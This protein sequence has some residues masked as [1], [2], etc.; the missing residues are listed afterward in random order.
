MKLKEAMKEIGAKWVRKEKGFRICFQKWVAAAWETDYFPDLSEKALT[1]EVSAWEV[2]RRFAE[3]QRAVK[4]NVEEGSVVNITVVNDEGD[5]VPFY[6]T[7]EPMIYL[8]R[9]TGTESILDQ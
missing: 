5:G 2:A 8:A 7:Q 6:A 4:D 9:N 3:V 1:S